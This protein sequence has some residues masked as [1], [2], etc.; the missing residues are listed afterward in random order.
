MINENDIR[1]YLKSFSEEEI[2]NSIYLFGL[3]FETDSFDNILDSIAAL[4]DE[5]NTLKR[6]IESRFENSEGKVLKKE[7]A[8]TQYNIIQDYQ[9]KSSVLKKMLMN[10]N[11]YEAVE[12]R[13]YEIE[14]R[15]ST[16]SSR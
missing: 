3:D 16:Q 8:T 2:A 9:K 7:Q 11:I 12:T 4:Y 10:D 14:K 1:K 5:V 6:I 15:N 13:I